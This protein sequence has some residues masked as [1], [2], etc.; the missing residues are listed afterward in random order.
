MNKAANT[1]NFIHIHRRKNSKKNLFIPMEWFSGVR[2]INANHIVYKA[3]IGISKVPIFNFLLKILTD[4]DNSLFLDARFEI[5][6]PKNEKDS[7]IPNKTSYSPTL[8]FSAYK[9]LSFD[10]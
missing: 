3:Y 9:M 4:S 5:F 7:I 6:G 2:S 8:E 1:D 10:L